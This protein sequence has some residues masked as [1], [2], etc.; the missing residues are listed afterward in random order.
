[1][2]QK[3]L[4]SGFHMILM[5]AECFFQR[6][7]G[8]SLNRTCFNLQTMAITCMVRW[9][10]WSHHIHV[11]KRKKCFLWILMVWLL[12]MRTTLQRQ[13]WRRLI[14]PYGGMLHV[15]ETRSLQKLC[16][17]LINQ[18]HMYHSA[19]YCVSRKYPYPSLGRFLVCTPHPLEISIPR[20]S[21]M[22]P[23]P[24]HDFCCNLKHL[25]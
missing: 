5:I 6:S 24:Q 15:F 8:T 17:A 16:Q 21:L 12:E 4:K 13:L 20:G 3:L 9:C 25:L 18:V 10:L 14:P 1:M 2:W 22:T 19:F 7:H 23:L 11:K